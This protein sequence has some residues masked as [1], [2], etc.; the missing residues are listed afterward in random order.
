MIG[1]IKIEAFPNG[2]HDNLFGDELS[3]LEPGW[4]VMEADPDTLPS[5]PF[6][7][8]DVEDV[9]GVPHMVAESWEPLPLPEPEQLEPAQQREEAYNTLAII[10]WDDGMITVTE[11]SQKWQYYAA[12]GSDKAGMLTGLIAE[13]KRTIREKYPDEAVQ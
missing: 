9:D 4:A 6:G 8:F 12:E 1:Q 11:A 10:P 2:A 13:A 3:A 7:N 5:F